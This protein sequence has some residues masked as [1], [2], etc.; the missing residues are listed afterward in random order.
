[1][2][3]PVSFFICG[4]ERLITAVVL[5]FLLLFSLLYRYTIY[6]DLLERKYYHTTATV[7]NQYQ[8]GDRQILKLKTPYFTFYTSTKEPLRDLRD[9]EVKVMLIQTKRKPTFLQFLKSFYAVSYIKGVLSKDRRYELKEA[10]AAQ[11]HDPF[12]KELFGALFLATALSK[13][14]RDRLSAFGLSH[15]VALSGFHLGVI[16]AVIG[17]AFTLLFKPLWARVIPYRNIHFFAGAVGLFTGGFYMA[18]VGFVPSLV[19]AFVLGVVIFFFF[20]RHV[21][22]LS[23]ELLAWVVLFIVVMEPRFLFSIGFWFSVA[24]VFCIYLFF[25]HLGDLN[26]WVQLLL[27]NIWVYFLMLPIVHYIFDAFSWWQLLSPF[28]SLL[29]VIF[30]PIESLLH[31]FGIG[32]MLDGIVEL[33]YSDVTVLHLKTPLWVLLLYL[34]LLAG[35]IYKQRL[36]FAALLLEIGWFV[37]EVA[38]F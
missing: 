38:K 12:A 35:S 31:L 3:E 10:I 33:L 19:R 7:M 1:M 36:I 24:G 15:L 28:L 21:K 14:L 27:F 32:S 22:L 30:Y 37:H 18:F 5:F 26:K 17:G 23:F 6:K 34:V 8:K 20:W 4:K 11:H 9:R 16:V 29:F 25:H 2:I 13:E